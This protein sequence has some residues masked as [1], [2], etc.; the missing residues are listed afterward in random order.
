M[1]RIGEVVFVAEDDKLFLT[2][3]SEK[4]CYEW[5]F[6]TITKVL[7]SSELKIS[8]TINNYRNARRN[9]HLEIKLD[10]VLEKI[11]DIKDESRNKDRF[12]LIF[13]IDDE[14]GD[15][16]LCSLSVFNAGGKRDNTN[17]FPTLE[18][19]ELELD[20]AYYK[21]KVKMLSVEPKVI[22]N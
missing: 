2:Y 21:L 9:M 19:T 7:V 17:L 22:A 12:S 4:Q 11:K 18:G 6:F 16:P 14:S 1:K 13:L 5:S 8:I 3:D 15:E 10:L 20:G